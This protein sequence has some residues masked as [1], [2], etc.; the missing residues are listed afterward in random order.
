MSLYNVCC[1]AVSQLLPDLGCTGIYLEQGQIRPV[2]GHEKDGRVS[3]VTTESPL[4]DTLDVV[5]S[6]ERLSMD[7]FWVL[8]SIV[9]VWREGRHTGDLVVGSHL[10]LGQSSESPDT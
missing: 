7:P 9:A 8:V 2:P 3:T 10:L 1:K 4:R 6:L 5:P